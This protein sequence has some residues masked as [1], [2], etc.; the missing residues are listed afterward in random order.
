MTFSFSKTTY[1]GSLICHQFLYY[2]LVILNHVFKEHIVFIRYFFMSRCVKVLGKLL[3]LKI[4]A[5]SVH[6]N[7]KIKENKL[8]SFKFYYIYLPL[9]TFY[10]KEK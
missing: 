6:A 10:C 1:D 9:C 4:K 2:H 5:C 8:D 3:S 7:I